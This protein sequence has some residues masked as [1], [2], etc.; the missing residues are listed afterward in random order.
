MNLFSLSSMWVLEIGK[1]KLM[2][3]W[4]LLYPKPAVGL[5]VH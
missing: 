5:P 1:K 3:L 2:T 4:F